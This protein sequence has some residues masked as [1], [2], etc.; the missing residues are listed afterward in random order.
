MTMK[1]SALVCSVNC[2]HLSLASGDHVPLDAAGSPDP[3]AVRRIAR[4]VVMTQIHI[5][6]QAGGHP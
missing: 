5:T 2:A 3:D 1:R 4:Y 6:P